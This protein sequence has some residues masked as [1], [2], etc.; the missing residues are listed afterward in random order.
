MGVNARMRAKLTRLEVFYIFVVPMSTDSRQFRQFHVDR[1]AMP[2]A[3]CDA[4]AAIKPYIVTALFATLQR[5]VE[6]PWIDRPNLAHDA[7]C[8]ARLSSLRWLD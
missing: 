6:C 1:I 4:R 7:L 3:G 8:G 2:S 5:D